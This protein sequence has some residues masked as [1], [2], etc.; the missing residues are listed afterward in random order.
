MVSPD[1]AF[2]GSIDGPETV[3]VLHRIDPV[4]PPICTI[5]R[6]FFTVL[7]RF[8]AGFAQVDTPVTSY[9]RKGYA[10]IGDFGPLIRRK[11]P[12]FPG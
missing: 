12:G 7:H 6:R 10:R 11:P 1:E 5:L 8:C 4:L 2:E 3:S 9:S